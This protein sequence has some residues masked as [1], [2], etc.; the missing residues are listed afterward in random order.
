MEPKDACVK[1]ERT[2][3]ARKK[4]KVE[5]APS[6][7]VDR[8]CYTCGKDDWELHWHEGLLCATCNGGLFI[9]QRYRCED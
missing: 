5:T 2:N 9:G 4:E 8:A 3:D 7:H 6:Q 1:C